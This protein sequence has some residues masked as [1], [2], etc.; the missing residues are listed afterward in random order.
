MLLKHQVLISK[1]LHNDLLLGKPRKLNPKT[2]DLSKLPWQQEMYLLA[3]SSLS[4]YNFKAS[5]TSGST[6]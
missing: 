4:N 5:Y 6:V 1:A 3:L 2:K